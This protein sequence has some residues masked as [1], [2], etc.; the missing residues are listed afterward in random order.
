MI[1]FSSAERETIK[2]TLALDFTIR[3]NPPVKSIILRGEPIIFRS[4][5][6][7][8]RVAADHLKRCSSI[9]RNTATQT[10]YLTEAHWALPRQH[11]A[12]WQLFSRR[13]LF[14]IRRSIQLN[15]SL[16]RRGRQDSNLR[17]P[18]PQAIVNCCYRLF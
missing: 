15:Y 12:S 14:D 7:R 16:I 18:A 5:S 6:K 3:L 2:P 11:S 10:G 1:S 17:P 9:I 13:D 4:C 8:Q